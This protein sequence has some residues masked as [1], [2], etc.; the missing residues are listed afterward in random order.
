IAAA[1]EYFAV[2]TYR[3]EQLLPPPAEP[4]APPSANTPDRHHFTLWHERAR[5][6]IFDHRREIF[7]RHGFNHFSVYSALLNDTLL[8]AMILDEL[9]LPLRLTDLPDGSAGKRYAA[10]RRTQPQL[11]ALPVSQDVPLVLPEWTRDGADYI[12][13]PHISSPAEHH[14]FNDWFCR[15]YLSRHLPDYL[16]HKY[17]AREYGTAPLTAADAACLQLTGQQLALPPA[18]RRALDAARRPSLF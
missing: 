9:R 2:Q 18:Q 11:F 12:P 5:R 13:Y 14:V 4:P 15:T 10:W 16:T 3:A 17:P 6:S 1:Q 7:Q 8:L